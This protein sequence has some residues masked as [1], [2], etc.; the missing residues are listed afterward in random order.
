MIVGKIVRKAVGKE[1]HL[2]IPALVCLDYQD[3]I[4]TNIAAQK[5]KKNSNKT[6]AAA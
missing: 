4:S 2:R 3:F 1:I 6:A 5:K